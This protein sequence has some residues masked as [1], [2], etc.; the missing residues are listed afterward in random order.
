MIVELSD[1][2]RGVT[3]AF[4]NHKDREGSVEVCCVCESVGIILAIK[5]HETNGLGIFMDMTVDF[6]ICSIK[7][8]VLGC[9]MIG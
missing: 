7:K 6:N 3:A 5:L 9:R 2:K 4:G 1:S 8:W